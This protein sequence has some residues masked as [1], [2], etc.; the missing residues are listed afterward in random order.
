MKFA[1][2][3]IL[4]VKRL[5]FSRDMQINPPRSLHSSVQSEK[6]FIRRSSSSY[7]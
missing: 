4:G 1:S 6:A 7:M 3:V 2:G 5:S